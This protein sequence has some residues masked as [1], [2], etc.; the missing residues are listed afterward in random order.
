MPKTL[1]ASLTFDYKGAM[2]KLCGSSSAKSPPSARTYCRL[3]RSAIQLGHHLLK[4]KALLPRRFGEWVR[5][6]YDFSS[7]TAELFMR[8]AEFAQ[9]HESVAQKVSQTALFELSAPRLGDE[10]RQRLVH[11]V[12]TGQVIS[13][14]QIKGLIRREPRKSGGSEGAD[15]DRGCQ[16]PLALLELASI[17][18]GGL[19]E[20]DLVRVRLIAASIEKEPISTL[21]VALIAASSS[22]S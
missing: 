22:R 11:A 1:P 7:R 16:P 21:A 4:V 12:E 18:I 9:S 6:N 2:Q 8:A 14:A 13:S 17:L 3:R 20:A 10:V 15:A 5:V 19:A